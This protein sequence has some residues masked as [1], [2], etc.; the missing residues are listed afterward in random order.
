MFCKNRNYVDFLRILYLVHLMKLL[1]PFPEIGVVAM[2][3]INN[4]KNWLRQIADKIINI[5]S[6]LYF[7]QSVYK[8]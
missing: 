2:Y 8:I 4:F 3:I 1:K 5:I 7:L 6:I